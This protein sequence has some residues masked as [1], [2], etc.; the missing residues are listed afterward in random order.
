[1][2]GIVSAIL[3]AAG[4]I[5][6]YY[7]IWKFK[8]GK[9]SAPSA[10]VTRQLNVLC[11]RSVVGISL[12]FLVIDLAGG[13]FSFLSL[14]ALVCLLNVAAHSDV[15]FLS[16]PVFAAG[17]FDTLASISYAAIVVLEVGVFVLAALL[18]PRYH[19]KIAEAKRID[20]EALS[21]APSSAANSLAAEAELEAGKEGAKLKAPEMRGRSR[22]V[23][24]MV[25][26][27]DAS[28]ER[29]E[30]NDEEP[31]DGVR[32]PDSAERRRQESVARTFRA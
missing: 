19:R 3:I 24:G 25:W 29:M 17:S 27:N 10:C 26:R 30:R 1:M 28:L 11:S 31:V 32:R 15:N 14:G 23:V 2:A 21:G 22:D 12:E 6:Q 4:L 5:P 9:S 13:V 20:E 16:Y 18:N 7:E 8:A